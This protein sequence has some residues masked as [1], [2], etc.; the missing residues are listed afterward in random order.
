MFVYYRV[1]FNG[2]D[3]QVAKHGRCQLLTNTMKNSWQST[4]W[5]R[6]STSAGSVIHNDLYKHRNDHRRYHSSSTSGAYDSKSAVEVVLRSS[7][8][9]LK[10]DDFCEK[11]C[12][13]VVTTATYTSG[14]FDSSFC[15]PQDI[16]STIQIK[17]IA[18]IFDCP[19]LGR[20]PTGPDTRRW[21]ES[22]CWPPPHA[23]IAKTL[24]NKVL[25]HI[26]KLGVS[27]QPSVFS[28]RAQRVHP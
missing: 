24:N 2:M 27:C 15:C 8:P 12:Y 16:L 3:V 4:C 28:A 21:L 20:L 22:C 6:C 9:V 5:T 18:T 26:Q 1:D 23:R 14:L 19:W 7:C 25:V 11:L 13:R 17:L 10:I